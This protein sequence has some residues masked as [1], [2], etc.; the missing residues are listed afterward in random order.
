[1]SDLKL[2][3]VFDVK[4]G[5]FKSEIKQNT[6]SIKQFGNGSVQTAGQTRQL[7]TALDNTNNKLIATN[8]MAQSV[9]RGLSGMLTGFSAGLL[10]SELSQTTRTFQVL[11]ATLE[12]ATGSKDKA[13]N[14]FERLQKFAASTPYSVKESIQAFIKLK[15][16]GLDPTEAA[17]NSYGNT[18]SA[19]GKSL[20]QFIEAVADASVSEFERLKEFGIKAKNQGDTIAFTFRKNKTEVA[21][22]AAAIE[23]YLQNLGKNEF[24]GAMERQA[25][26][27]DGAVSNMGDSW[28]QFLLK[29]SD[30][31]AGNIMED[32]VRGTASSLN[33]LAQHVEKINT[34]FSGGLVIAAGHAVSAIS[35][36]TAATAKS[37]VADQAKAQAALSAAKSDEVLAVSANHRA[38]QEQAAAKRSLAN[39]TNTYARTRAIKNLA[40]ANGQLAA[41]EKLVAAATSNLTVATNKLSIARKGLSLMSGLVGGL[42]GLLTI[43]GFA[44]YSFAS[45]ALAADDNTK[46]LTRSIEEALG[47]QKELAT[48][49]LQTDVD[50]RMARLAQLQQ[51]IADIHTKLAVGHNQKLGL[52]GKGVIADSIE[53]AKKL[54]AEITQLNAKILS[55]SGDKDP[56]KKT[57][58]SSKSPPVDKKL[59]SDLANVEQSLL[60]KE[61]VINASYIR[62]QSIVD[63]SLASKLISEQKYNTLSFQL[64]GKKHLALK[65]LSDQKLAQEKDWAEQKATAAQKIINDE[66]QAALNVRE[67]ADQIRRD[68]YAAELAELNGFHLVKMEVKAGQTEEELEQARNRNLMLQQEE[69]NHQDTK[70]NLQ[71]KHTG[72]YGELLNKQVAFE[73]A[74]GKDKLLIGANTIQG[75]ASQMSGQ[76]KTAFKIAKAAS[77]AQAAIALPSAV[78]QSFQNGGGYPFGLIPAG[79]MLAQGVMQISKIQSQQP[80]G[81]ES[82]GYIGNNNV[83]EFGERNKPEVLEFAGRNYLL[84]GN[85]GSVFNQSQLNEING[86]SGNGGD[87]F[88]ISSSI[89]I[90]GNADESAM[91]DLIERNYEAVYSAVVQAKADRGEAA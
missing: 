82:G 14:A 67:Q 59:G 25:A 53:E 90:Q 11:R 22:N 76:S 81:F 4:N 68:G 64:D 85:Q 35:A 61:G 23:Q 5:K 65:A 24:G 2:G 44:M 60:D 42:P 80:P 12:T 87:T 13:A 43:A 15:N 84:G 1:M 48:Q 49:A 39:A 55:L 19:M 40:I 7:S 3:I 6:Q 57:E 52:F 70:R 18:A 33:F 75:M 72:F 34:L 38:V 77:L 32:T 17:L 86:G 31:G 58:P 91:V 50:E 83:I 41:S 73:R 47:K 9:T 89:T 28:D 45:S 54:G 21:N 27:Y 62:Q 78:L 20:D 16:L 36:K 88:S 46:G 37:I 51:K 56:K 8:R 79:L 63:N 26:T 10:I 71:N 69:R 66:V 74:T 29:I 30:G